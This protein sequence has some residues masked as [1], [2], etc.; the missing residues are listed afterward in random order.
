MRISPTCD[1]DLIFER[2]AFRGLCTLWAP[3]LQPARDDTAVRMASGT[4]ATATARA[5]WP[6]S[7]AAVTAATCG[8]TS[9]ASDTPAASSASLGFQLPPAAH[10]QRRLR[11]CRSWVV[12][13][14]QMASERCTS[15]AEAAHSS[16]LCNRERLAAPELE[17]FTCAQ[18]GRGGDRCRYE[19]DGRIDFLSDLRNRGAGDAQTGPRFLIR[20]GFGCRWHPAPP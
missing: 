2:S 9:A 20:N 4:A 5:W 17:R 15:Q 3:A 19:A 10:H 12:N 14:L 11:S 18:D 1:V 6:C 16:A 7:A 8:A 13:V